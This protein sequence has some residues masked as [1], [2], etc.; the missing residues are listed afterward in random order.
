MTLTHLVIKQKA[1]NEILLSHGAL[2]V[3][4]GIIARFV[5]RTYEW[6]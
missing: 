2:V 1:P 3:D 4:N 6:L 5:I